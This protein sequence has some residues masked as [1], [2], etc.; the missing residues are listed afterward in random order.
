[1]DYAGRFRS[2]SAIRIRVSAMSF[3]R[4]KVSLKS[5]FPNNATSTI[6]PALKVGYAMTAGMSE[7]DRSRKREEK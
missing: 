7:S 4:V 3:L 1:M 6:V 2:A 5:I